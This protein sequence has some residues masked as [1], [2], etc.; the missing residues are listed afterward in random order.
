M[1]VVLHSWERFFFI[2]VLL[3]QIFFVFLQQKF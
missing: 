2:K 3:F 1:N